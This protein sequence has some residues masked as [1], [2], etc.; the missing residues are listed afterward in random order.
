MEQSDVEG[1]LYQVYY[2]YAGTPTRFLYSSQRASALRLAR[3]M[4]AQGAIV[5]MHRIKPW[6]ARVRIEPDT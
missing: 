5:V 3:L 1:S 6:F 4:K 2:R